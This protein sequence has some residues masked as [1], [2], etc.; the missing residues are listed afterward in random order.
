ML[1]DARCA[2]PGAMP[3]DKEV[4]RAHVAA[5]QI[6]E[7]PLVKIVRRTEPGLAGVVDQDVYGASLVDQTSHCCK[8][9]EVGRYE[10]SSASLCR[11]LLDHLRTT[12]RVA[13]VDYDF[14][15]I[16]CELDGGGATDAGGRSGHEC[17]PQSGCRCA[18]VRAHAPSP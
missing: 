15:A 7:S 2:M 14:P 9:V 16:A 1:P 18:A 11:N 8:V 17:E 12:F 3:G 5:E 4:R 13:T 6:V 10:T